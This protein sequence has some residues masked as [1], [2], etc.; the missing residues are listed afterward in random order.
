MKIKNILIAGQH[1]LDFHP[2][3]KQL[4]MYHLRFK[5]IDAISQNDMDWADVYVGFAPNESFDPAKFNWVHTFNA[6]V[7]NYLAI[8][9]WKDTLLT[10]TIS[11]F[12]EKM[13]TYCLS[14]ILADL[15]YH[16]RF[17]AQQKE[18]VWAVK[19]PGSLKEQTVTILGT[20][21]IGQKIAEVFSR[22]GATV[23]GISNNGEHKSYFN[24]ITNMEN[25]TT[26]L[27]QS[28]YII[29]T[30][31]LTLD[32]EKLLNQSFFNHLNDVFFINVGRGKVVDT[33]NLLNAL[34]EGKLRYAVLDVFESEP[35]KE[36]SELWER[37][38]IT[39]T[40][41]ISALTDIDNAV[42]CFYNTLKKIE[43]NESLE[44]QV[45]FSKGY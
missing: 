6:G 34:N 13:S 8:S 44:N 41:H 14:Y 19:S 1:E 28:N 15:Q 31:P 42:S 16:A 29:S 26:T 21:E 10:R 25:A 32:T 45:D 30:L 22:F 27:E 40:P 11:D 20:G 23:N 3:L 39:I 2:Y 36:D 5:S 17:K 43:N 35:L 18:K 4:E 7:N 12:G 33:E 24:Y 38:D 37:E 9:G